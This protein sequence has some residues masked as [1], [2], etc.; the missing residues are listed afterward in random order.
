MKN[1]LS[2]I[3]VLLAAIV[4]CSTI[5]AQ[6]TYKLQYKFEKGKTY[7]YKIE[8]NTDMTQQMMGREMKF[9]TVAHNIARFKIENTSDDGSADIIFS[10]D[11][12]YI[13]TNMRGHDTTMVLDQMIGK[14]IE[15]NVSNLGKLYKYKILDTLVNNAWSNS[16]AQQ[17]KN[18]FRVLNGKNIKVGDKWS[19]TQIDTIDNMGGK[20]VSTIDFDYTLAGTAEKLGHK[21]L[22]IPYTAKIKI[23]GKGNMR[24]IDLFIEGNGKSSGTAYLDANT[25][26]NVYIESTVDNEMTMATT[27][28]QTMT[29]P[30]S[31]STKSVISLI[32]D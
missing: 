19:A 22:N 18:F 16:I 27:G 25:G 1:H 13:K 24:G 14:R 21:C 23:E 3:L 20:I 5:Y 31:Q 12:S 28:Q 10:L 30:I 6:E 8:S 15:M 17:S 2:K 29:I 7:V 4:F 9:N 26:M 11:S 32:S